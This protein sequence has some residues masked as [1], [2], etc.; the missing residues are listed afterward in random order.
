MACKGNQRMPSWTAAG[1]WPISQGVGQVW[2]AGISH[3]EAKGSHGAAYDWG[4]G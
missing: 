2:S 4:L 3:G 1:V